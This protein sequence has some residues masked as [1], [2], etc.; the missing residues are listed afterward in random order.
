[1][2]VDTSFP[3]WTTEQRV[4]WAEKVHSLRLL[5]LS[6]EGALEGAAREVEDAAWINEIGDGETADGVWLGVLWAARYLVCEEFLLGAVVSRA[7]LIAKIDETI[8][9]ETDTPSSPQEQEAAI[10]DLLAQKAMVE[11]PGGYRV[12]DRRVCL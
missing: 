6:D 7:E 11:V 8:A 3:A 2:S 1:V 4:E 9:D 10:A 12:A 5:G